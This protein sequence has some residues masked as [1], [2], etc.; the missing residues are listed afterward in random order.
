[1]K[2]ILL[3]LVVLALLAVA[4]SCGASD[5]PTYDAH[6]DTPTDAYKRL[7]A[8]VKAGNA[9]AIRAEMT[10]KTI[11]FN[12]F[13]AQRFG[14]SEDE[15]IRY[16]MTSTT[17][18]DTLPQIR[19]ERVKDNMGAVEVWNSKES[20]WDDLP[21]MIEDGR[22]KL[23]YGDGYAGT[24]RSPGKGR[25]EVEREAANA[26]RPPLTPAPNANMPSASKR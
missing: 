6:G 1:M 7:F 10:K 3:L 16:G 9:D 13:G 25:N 14:K 17:Q 4:L 12:R 22:W 24:W 26:L 20:R 19:D 5:K 18:T 21:F 2:R 8:A 23:A 15:E 11:E